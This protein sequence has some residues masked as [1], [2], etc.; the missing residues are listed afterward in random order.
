MRISKNIWAIVIVFTLS[1][2]LIGCLSISK[3]PKLE[4]AE[5]SSVL[6]DNGSRVHEYGSYGLRFA[7]LSHWHGEPLDFMMYH[8]QATNRK[9]TE[10]D[11][12]ANQTIR[13]E[14][15]SWVIELSAS[16][17]RITGWF[18]NTITISCHCPRY[19][20]FRS[21]VESP[22]AIRVFTL[23]DYITIDMQSGQ[24]VMLHDL[25]DVSDEFVKHI[26]TQRV[27]RG[28]GI[29]TVDDWD[30]IDQVSELLWEWIEE[31]AFEDLRNRVD[32]AS[33]T[34]YEVLSIP[35]RN[36]VHRNNFYVEPGRLI[37]VFEFGGMDCRLTIYLDDISDFLL[38]D[39]W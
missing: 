14:K 27:V 33:M 25:V 37:L 29:G 28:S 38:V 18:P 13:D 5:S 11:H 4:S 32:E 35:N 1:A 8:V 3:Y 24:R 26:Q 10:R 15:V 31:M 19:L 9:M 17:G 7:L 12:I 21:T 20:S 30:L 22:P 34:N 36:I 23:S 2:A 39:P 6:P 16:E